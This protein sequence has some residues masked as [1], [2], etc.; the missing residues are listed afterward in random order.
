MAS[1]CSL[2]NEVVNFQIIVSE[3]F[4]CGCI[5]HTVCLERF[6]KYA[7]SKNRDCNYNGYWSPYKTSCPKCCYPKLL[8]KNKK[9]V[10]SKLLLTKQKCKIK[11]SKL[12]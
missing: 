7:E 11:L 8:E 1:I 3:K 9:R 5:F 10:S 6:I 2:C 4:S 12:F